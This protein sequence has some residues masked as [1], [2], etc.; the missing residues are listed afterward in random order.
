MQFLYVYAIINNHINFKY[1]ILRLFNFVSHYSNKFN[2]YIYSMLVVKYLY[3]VQSWNIKTII[4]NNNW[5]KYKNFTLF[6][7]ENI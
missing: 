5:S 6:A 7:Y 2:N 3:Y 1:I 4:K